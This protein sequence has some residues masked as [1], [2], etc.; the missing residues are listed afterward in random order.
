MLAMNI[1]TLILQQYQEPR[2]MEHGPIID[3]V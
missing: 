2:A 3:Y 1:L